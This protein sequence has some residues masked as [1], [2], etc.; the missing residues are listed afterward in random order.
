MTPIVTRA[1]VPAD[2]AAMAVIR[3]R[4]WETEEYWLSRIGGY[5]SGEQSPQHG[6]A[7]RAMF[8]AVN[9]E[10]VVGFAAGHRTRRFGC[11]G[12][13]Q[14]ISVDRDSRGHGIAGQLIARMAEWFS[15]QGLRRICVNVEP[16]NTAARALYRLFGAEPLS[17]YWMVWD[18]GLQR[19]A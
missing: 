10:K 19:R 8:V 11:D 18:N 4:E 13:L 6:L 2:I 16:A 1:A 5:L 9:G 12:E 14:W 15:E 7:A 17:K 3:A